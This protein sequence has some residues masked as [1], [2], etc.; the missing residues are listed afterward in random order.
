MN[1]QTTSLIGSI[2]LGAAGV[3]WRRVVQ[4]WD[5]TLAGVQTIEIKLQANT[6]GPFQLSVQNFQIFGGSA[7][8]AQTNGWI[9]KI[10]QGAFNSKCQPK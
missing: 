9:S 7:Q 1:P 4:I 5:T 2:A 8:S 10:L 6:S 3:V